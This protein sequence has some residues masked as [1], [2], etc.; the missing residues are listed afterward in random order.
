MDEVEKFI[1]RLRVIYLAENLGAVESLISIPAQMT[2]ASILQEER[3]KLGIKDTLIRLSVGIE[4]VE[5]L[6]EDIFNALRR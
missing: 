4:D 6:K 3:L 2:H 5:D 1:S